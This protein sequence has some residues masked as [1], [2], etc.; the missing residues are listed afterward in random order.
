MPVTKERHLELLT[1]MVK[2][3]NLKI[4]LSK[5]GKKEILERNIELKC[6]KISLDINEIQ[7]YLNDLYELLESVNILVPYMPI[8]EY[9]GKVMCFDK[10]PKN[11]DYR[12]GKY[13]ILNVDEIKKYLS[14]NFIIMVNTVSD[15]TSKDNI[16]LECLIIKN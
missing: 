15:D 13:V 5:D 7:L 4:D 6:S 11:D 2:Y 12:H 10:S 9:N 1:D 8:F 3:K 14:D 16:K